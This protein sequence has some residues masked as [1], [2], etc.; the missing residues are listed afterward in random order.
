MSVT[1]YVK[2]TP[3]HHIKMK[4]YRVELKSILNPRDDFATFYSNHPAR[5]AYPDLTRRAGNG[6]RLSSRDF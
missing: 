4:S 2:V 6:S 3:Y 1:I 5:A